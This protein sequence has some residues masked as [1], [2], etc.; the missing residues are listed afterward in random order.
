MTPTDLY[1]ATWDRTLRKIVASVRDERRPDGQGPFREHLTIT[2]M[3]PIARR[4]GHG[5]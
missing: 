3:L 5:H 1:S 2:S 4:L